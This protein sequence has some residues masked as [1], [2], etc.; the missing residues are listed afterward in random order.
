MKEKDFLTVK[1]A[2]EMAGVTPYVIRASIRG[3]EGRIKLNAHRYGTGRNNRYRIDRVDFE[4]WQE[5]CR[6]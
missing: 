5:R 3:D 4:R 6:V 2:A 1:E